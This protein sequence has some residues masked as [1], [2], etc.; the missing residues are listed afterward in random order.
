MYAF[1]RPYDQ[2]PDR[3]GVG[4]RV[5]VTAEHRELIGS[6]QINEIRQFQH[7]AIPRR[8]R[9]RQ[10]RSVDVNRTDGGHRD[11]RMQ[12]QSLMI[13]LLVR[14]VAAEQ[15]VVLSA[16]WEL[17]QHR[18]ALLHARA[19]LIIHVGRL[20]FEYATQHYLEYVLIV[21]KQLG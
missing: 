9:Q 17:R 13:V 2:I 5:Q 6:V 21:R 11:L 16:D 1:L 18:Y 12:D 14:V 15:N 7:R 4:P 20:A 8:L 19:V 3:G 10:M